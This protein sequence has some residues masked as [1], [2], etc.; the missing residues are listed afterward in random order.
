MRVAGLCYLPTA[1]SAMYG[2]ILRSTRQVKI[3]MAVSVGAL[4]LK[5]ALSYVL[6]FG[7]FGVPALGI[8]G[9]AVATCI[10]RAAGVRGHAGVHLQ[11]AS[12]R[13]R[14]ACGR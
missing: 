8:M 3:P 13:P 7:H 4:S 12:C 1:I 10:A 11:V 9:G 5:T 2:M 14:P 6:I